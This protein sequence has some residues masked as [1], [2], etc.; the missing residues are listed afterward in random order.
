LPIDVAIKNL[1]EFVK[2]LE[3]HLDQLKEHK[4]YAENNYNLTRNFEY[5]TITCGI[6]Y[7]QSIIT[8]CNELIVHLEK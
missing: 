1:K 3:Q 8:W 7:F 6:H 2:V 5:S 4:V